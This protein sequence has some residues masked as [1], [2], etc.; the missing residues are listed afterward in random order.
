MG[1]QVRDN[2]ECGSGNRHNNER[3]VRGRNVITSCKF[4]RLGWHAIVLLIAICTFFVIV[5][6]NTALCVRDQYFPVDFSLF[7]ADKASERNHRDRSGTARRSHISKQL[8]VVFDKGCVSMI[9]Y[10]AARHAHGSQW[11][12]VEACTY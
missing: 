10:D 12:N 6:Q 7:T 8:S 11:Q 4:R 2:V 5:S 9:S 1:G 3:E